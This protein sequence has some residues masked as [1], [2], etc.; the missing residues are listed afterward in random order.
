MARVNIVGFED[1]TECDEFYSQNLARGISTGINGRPGHQYHLSLNDDAY[2]GGLD[3][4]GNKAI[5]NLPEMWIRIYTWTDGSGYYTA[6]GHFNVSFF[7]TAGSGIGSITSSFSGTNLTLGSTILTGI[8]GSGT[9][10]DYHCWRYIEAY[11]PTGTQKAAVVKQNGVVLISG[12]GNFPSTNFGYIGFGGMWAPI[13]IDDIAIDNSEWCGPGTI[14]R[15]DST[16]LQSG[17]GPWLNAGGG[18]PTYA[19]LDD[20]S[21]IGHLD[22]DSTYAVSTEENAPLLSYYNYPN[23]FNRAFYQTAKVKA[24]KG[25]TWVRDDSVTNLYQMSVRCSGTSTTTEYD[26]DIGAGYTGRAVV[27]TMPAL[28]PF[29]H[30]TFWTDAVLRPYVSVTKITTQTRNLYVTATALFVEVQPYF[31]AEYHANFS[32]PQYPFPKI[33]SI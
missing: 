31:P 12:T 23:D 21:G 5:F 13:Y 32:Q 20:L 11:L 16:N 33:V 2:I 19:D 4:Y 30:P 10:I 29:N 14:I 1:K 17:G 18:T 24:V 27:L 25:M 28:I 3:T 7:N 22:W 9:A 15:L 26:N 8:G 6:P